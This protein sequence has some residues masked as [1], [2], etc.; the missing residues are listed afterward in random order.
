MKLTLEM[1]DN[2]FS[3]LR[4]APDDFASELKLA[5]CVKWYELGRLTQSK[6]AEIS[7]LSRAEFIDA[8]RTYRVPAVQVE[9][10]KLKAEL[11]L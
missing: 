9:V 4:Q 11:A 8:L 3:A 7:G 2:A 10:D 6:A 5:A 1:P